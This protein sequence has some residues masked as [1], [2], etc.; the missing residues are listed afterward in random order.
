MYIDT[1]I[2]IIII[3]Y[4]FLNETLWRRNKLMGSQAFFFNLVCLQ[5]HSLTGQFYFLNFLYF[6]SFIEKEIINFRA[7]FEYYVKLKMIPQDPLAANNINGT[8]PNIISL[9]SFHY[10]AY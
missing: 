3:I 8:E 1:M 6:Y 4:P 7:Q 9:D 5:Q 2:F 10:H